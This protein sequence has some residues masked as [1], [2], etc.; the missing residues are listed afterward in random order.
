MKTLPL[1][2][3]TLVLLTGCDRPPSDPRLPPAPHPDVEA[4]APPVPPVEAGPA[5]AGGV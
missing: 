3:L 4:P 1:L 2:L 5:A